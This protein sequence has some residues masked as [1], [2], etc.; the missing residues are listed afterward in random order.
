MVRRSLRLIMWAYD[1]G[2]VGQVPGESLVR[3]PLEEAVVVAPA[4]PEALAGCIESDTRNDD[5]VDIRE[6][7]S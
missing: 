1:G 6:I 5:Q 3:E 2:E 4:M 7:V